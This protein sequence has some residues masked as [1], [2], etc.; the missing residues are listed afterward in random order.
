MDDQKVFVY[1]MSGWKLWKQTNHEVIWGIAFCCIYI[2]AGNK[3]MKKTKN[4]SVEWKAF[5]NTMGIMEPI[6]NIN[7]S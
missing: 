5:V 1:T 2:T 3:E 4:K 7:F 6:W